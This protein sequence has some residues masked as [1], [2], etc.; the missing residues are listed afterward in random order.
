MSR[1]KRRAWPTVNAAVV[2]LAI[3]FGAFTPCRAETEVA[4][5][6]LNQPGVSEQLGSTI[7]LDTIFTNE[8]GQQLRLRDLI[9]KPTLLLP[10]YFHCPNTCSLL[11]AN[12]AGALNEVA[13]VAGQ[14]YQVIALSFDEHDTPSSALQ[15]KQNY[16]PILKKTFPPETWSFLTGSPES[17]TALTRAIGF[18]FQRT[19]NHLFVHPSVLVSISPTGK[20]IRYIY[21]A[22]FLPFD[23]SMAINE[24]AKG[25]PGIS[26][27][28]F[29]NYC[30]SYNPESRRYVFNT[31]RIFAFSTLLILIIFYLLFLRRRQE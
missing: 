6:A 22:D 17:I 10:V 25:T 16:T 5:A 8:T 24:A 19:A 26:I 31:F 28:K 1:E 2:L 7:P 3:L 9:Q 23:L 20:I 30:F 18:N 14:D 21:G 27:K 29:M 12:L 11:L 4:A 13:G 15:A